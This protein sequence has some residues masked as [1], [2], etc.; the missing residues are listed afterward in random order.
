[1]WRV[2]GLDRTSAGWEDHGIW[3]GAWAG[4][5]LSDGASCVPA[6]RDGNARSRDSAATSGF[7]VTEGVRESI[8]ALTVGKLVSFPW[9]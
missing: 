1:M 8:R 3:S 4:S 9:G 2:S 5:A 6:S 7:D